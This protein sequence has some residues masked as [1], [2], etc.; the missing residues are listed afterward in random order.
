MAAVMI[1]A[2]QLQIAHKLSSPIPEQNWVT[3]SCQVPNHWVLQCRLRSPMILLSDI[4][5]SFL[6]EYTFL[7]QQFLNLMAPWQAS[8]PTVPHVTF[9][10][11]VP[12][13]HPMSS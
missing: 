12:E 5:P 1:F 11:G 9:M 6:E 3:S 7:D 4:S 8:V 2:F 13:P 10:D